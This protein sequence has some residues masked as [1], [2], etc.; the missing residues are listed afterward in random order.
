[1]RGLYRSTYEKGRGFTGKEWWAAVSAAAGGASFEEFNARYIDGREPFP[2]AADFALAGLSAVVDSNRIPRVGIQTRGDSAPE[3]VVAVTPGSAFATAGGLAGDQ[4]V[5]VG[6]IDGS[7]GSW[8]PQF[9]AKYGTAA[10]GTLIPV[11]VQRGGQSVTLQMPLRF[12]TI[13]SY[14]LVIDPKASP[15]AVQVRQGIMKGS[16][17]R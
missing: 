14:R 10:E 13:R 5:R 3:A 16:V 12:I 17:A 7:S 8:A 9:R 4:L 15:A 2:Y 11:V 6:D 1:M